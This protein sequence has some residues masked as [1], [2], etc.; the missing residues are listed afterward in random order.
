MTNDQEFLE[1]VAARGNDRAKAL[2]RYGQFYS[3]PEK[4]DAL[5]MLRAEY[6]S[7]SGGNAYRGVEVLLSASSTGDRKAEELLNR[8][9][10]CDPQA[11][12]LA[13]TYDDGNPPSPAVLDFFGS[14]L[15]MLAK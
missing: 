3:E 7:D 8:V 12:S 14:T 2:L 5:R 1:A 10:A 11:I 13:R 9:L 6:A 4:R 15:E